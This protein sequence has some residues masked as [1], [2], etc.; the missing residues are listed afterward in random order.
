MLLDI[1]EYN[2]STSWPRSIIILLR[3]AFLL[4]KNSSNIILDV[5]L[6]IMNIFILINSLIFA[7]PIIIDLHYLR[8]WCLLKLLIQVPALCSSL[9]PL[10]CF[11]RILLHHITCTNLLLRI[12][13]ITIPI[14]LWGAWHSFLHEMQVHHIVCAALGRAARLKVLL[15]ACHT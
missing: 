1:R 12:H 9:N 14:W 3:M 13:R 6:Q 10:L 7:A 2:I 11:S 15:R 4:F 5:Y 8:R